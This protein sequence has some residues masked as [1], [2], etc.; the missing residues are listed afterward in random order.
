VSLLFASVFSLGVEVEDF[1]VKSSS[2]FDVGV[3]FQL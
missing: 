2:S 1:E 3:M